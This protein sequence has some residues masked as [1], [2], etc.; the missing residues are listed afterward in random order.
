[1]GGA[2]GAAQFV[3]G[4]YKSFNGINLTVLERMHQ[5]IVGGGAYICTILGSS[6][7]YQWL[8]FSWC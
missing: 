3:R 2:G 6:P 7:V 1:M 5:F 8:V 4:N